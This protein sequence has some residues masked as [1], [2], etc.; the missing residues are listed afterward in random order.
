[1]VHALHFICADFTLKRIVCLCVLFICGMQSVGKTKMP[2]QSKVIPKSHHILLTYFQP[3]VPGC[4]GTGSAQ[5]CCYSTIAQALWRRAQAVLLVSGTATAFQTHPSEKEGPFARD[6]FV[7]FPPLA[8][9]SINETAPS[10]HS[11][12]L[13]QAIGYCAFGIGSKNHHCES[14][15]YKVKIKQRKFST[16]GSLFPRKLFSLSNQLEIDS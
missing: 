2:L 10:H 5:S 13:I 4:V 12:S 6:A 8:S 1:M 14:V 3:V 16:E 11:S 15:S 9:V 7:S